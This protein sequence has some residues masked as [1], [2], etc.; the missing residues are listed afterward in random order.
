MTWGVN[1]SCNRSLADGARAGTLQIVGALIGAIF[2]VGLVLYGLNHEGE[3][4]DSKKTAAPITVTPQP[5]PGQR[6]PSQGQQS[7]EPQQAQSQQGGGQ[8]PSAPNSTA[9]QPSGPSNPSTTTGQGP[10]ARGS[11]NGNAGNKANQAP[12]TASPSASPPNPANN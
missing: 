11:Q 6:N 4:G 7:P 5:A 10:N 9:T 12:A 8:Q 3:E 2:I 1:K